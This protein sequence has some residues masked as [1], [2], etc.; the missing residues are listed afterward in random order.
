MPPL[1][2]RDRRLEKKIAAQTATKFEFHP[3]PDAQV[4]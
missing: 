4:Y 1:L 3:D 2:N